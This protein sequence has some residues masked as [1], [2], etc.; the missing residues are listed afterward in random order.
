MKE[1]FRDTVIGHLIRW[2]TGGKWLQHAEDRD[3]SLWR[4]YISTEKSSRLSSYGT[5]E[6][7]KTKYRSTTSNIT[8]PQSEKD[9]QV[10]STPA[11]ASGTSSGHATPVPH[12]P[13]K[14]NSLG[15]INHMGHGRD[16]QEKA[17]EP[18]S[19]KSNESKEADKGGQGW[20]AGAIGKEGMDVS[21]TEGQVGGDPALQMHS[22]TMDKAWNAVQLEAGR[23]GV[24]LPE[25]AKKDSEKGRVVN[26]VVWFGPS[27][28][29]VS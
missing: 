26:V 10:Y 4:M 18:S 11:S 20:V 29:E 6:P 21:M 19:L 13:N 15:A 17:R 16:T 9:E 28:P 12:K 27:D 25:D 3:P 24:A 1:L 23:E 5:L 22:E 8:T 2:A 14:S 7:I